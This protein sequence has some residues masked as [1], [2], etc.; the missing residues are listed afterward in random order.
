M[1]DAELVKAGLPVTG[2]MKLIGIAYENKTLYIG[3]WFI[4]FEISI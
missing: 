3:F 1:I 4:N 2:K